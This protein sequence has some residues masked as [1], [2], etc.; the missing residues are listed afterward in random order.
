MT[1]VEGDAS[2]EDQQIYFDHQVNDVVSGMRQLLEV[3][4][5]STGLNF[6]Q[7]TTRTWSEFVS[8][9]YEYSDSMS[10]FKE[11]DIPDWL[12][13]REEKMLQLALNY[14]MPQSSMQQLQSVSYTHLTLPTSDL[15]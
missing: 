2:A 7:L 6:L 12:I 11:D 14:S 15:V 8:I 13:Q 10:N 4:P 5:Q 9:C 3:D 1:F